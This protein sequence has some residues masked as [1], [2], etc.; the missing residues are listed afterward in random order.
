V[1]RP[2]L[3]AI[4]KAGRVVHVEDNATA[5]TLALTGDDLAR[6]DAAFPRRRRRRGVATL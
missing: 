4:P 1:R 5:A 6:L 3:F 2:S